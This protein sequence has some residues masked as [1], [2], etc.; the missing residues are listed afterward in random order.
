M[1][2]LS[3]SSCWLGRSGGKLAGEIRELSLAREKRREREIFLQRNEAKAGARNIRE[4]GDKSMACSLREN[5]ARERGFFQNNSFL[6]G[7]VRL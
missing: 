2:F 3:G 1:G 5:R 6:L 4:E 7:I